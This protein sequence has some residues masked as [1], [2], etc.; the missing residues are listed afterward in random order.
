MKKLILLPTLLCSALFCSGVYANAKTAEYTEFVGAAGAV[1]WTQG[2]IQAE[3]MGAAPPNKPPHVAPLLACRAAIADAQRNLLEAVKGVRVQANTVVERYMLASDEIRTS[4]EGVIRNATITEKMPLADSTCRVTVSAPLA[5]NISQ[6]IYQK[7]F[8]EDN[9]K[10]AMYYIIDGLGY[11]LS[12]LAPKAAHAKSNMD[13][14]WTERFADLENRILK[15]EQQIAAG[16]IE[17]AKNNLTHI[18]NETRPTGLII[19]V[20]GGHFVPSLSPKLFSEKGKKLYP[21][22]QA[23]SSILASGRLVSLFTRDPSFAQKHP[24]VGDR[25]WLIKA[26]QSASSRTDLT[27]N[28]ETAR[29]LAQL[30]KS[31]FFDDAGVIIV[32]D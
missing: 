13:S 29:K 1:N 32:L 7:S 4:V 20:R 3:G 31:N 9:Q 12:W 27:V 25:P 21:K 2:K 17:A 5:G 11:G 6:S 19:D 24:V 22:E 14:S 8:D 10:S 26:R 15:L 16:N 23:R 28:E 18:Q 30:L